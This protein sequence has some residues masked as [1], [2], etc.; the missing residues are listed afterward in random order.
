MVVVVAVGLGFPAADQHVIMPLLLSPSAD[1]KYRI[2]TIASSTKTLDHF[3]Q[4]GVLVVVCIAAL[5]FVGI[6]TVFCCR[7]SKRCPSY[8]YSRALFDGG[9][10]PCMTAPDRRLPTLASAA[11]AAAAAAYPGTFDRRPYNKRSSDDDHDTLSAFLQLP[12][13]SATS[14]SSRSATPPPEYD[15]I[16]ETTQALSRPPTYRSLNDRHP[17]GT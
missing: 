16:C 1:T 14:G 11:P 8:G 6:F 4:I 7:C 2:T 5:I 13:Y 9:P 12:P 3:E 17:D 10:R 15:S